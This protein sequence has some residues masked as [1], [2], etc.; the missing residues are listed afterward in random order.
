[1]KFIYLLLQLLVKRS[2][3]RIC[4]PSITFFVAMS[5]VFAMEDS[6]RHIF[7]FTGFSVTNWYERTNLVL[8]RAPSSLSVQH[9]TCNMCHTTMGKKVCS[10]MPPGRHEGRPSEVDTSCGE[11]IEA[12]IDRSWTRFMHDPRRV[13]PVGSGTDGGWTIPCGLSAVS[14]TDGG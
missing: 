4:Y 5:P 8:L 2:N 10:S 13:W 14:D 6:R 9:L 3:R 1:M 7:C 12:A 11:A